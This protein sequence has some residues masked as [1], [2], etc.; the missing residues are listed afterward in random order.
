MK[1]KRILKHSYNWV[2]PFER[3]SRFP[4][5]DKPHRI[6]KPEKR[7][8]YL[9]VTRSLPKQLESDLFLINDSGEVLEEVISN[10]SGFVTSDEDVHPFSSKASYTYKNVQPG[11]A[12]KVEEYNEMLD[13]DFVLG[14]SVQ[15]KSEELGEI[16]ISISGTRGGIGE[17]VILWDT[18]ETGPNSKK[19]VPQ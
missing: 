2:P 13:S 4:G 17:T 9:W 8:P 1:E 11:E 5:N 7:K 14:L 6:G 10:I 19:I 16:E 3:K 18:L 15:I 12:V